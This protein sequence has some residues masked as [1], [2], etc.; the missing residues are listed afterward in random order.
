MYVQAGG[1][2][3][4]MIQFKCERLLVHITQVFWTDQHSWYTHTRSL[5]LNALSCLD[6]HIEL[7][8]VPYTKLQT[9]TGPPMN[10]VVAVVYLAP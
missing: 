7:Y 6:Q 5:E 10:P 2:D 1:P 9:Y 8:T 3:R 4:K